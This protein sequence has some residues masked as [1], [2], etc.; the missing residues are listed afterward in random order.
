MTF[1]TLMYIHSL[2][3]QDEEAK[4]EAYNAA[5]DH[6]EDL[7]DQGASREEIAEAKQRKNTAYRIHSDALKALNEFND[8]D[9]R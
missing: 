5:R 3:K 2:M 1:E 9:W 4:R 6:L 7:K 8:H